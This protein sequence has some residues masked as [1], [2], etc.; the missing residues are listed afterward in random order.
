MGVNTMKRQYTERKYKIEYL[1]LKDKLEW[2][3]SRYNRNGSEYIQKYEKVETI[4]KSTIT[5]IEENYQ[6]YE[7]RLAQII[8]LIHEI[9]RD[10][11]SENEFNMLFDDVFY[12][13]SYQV[14]KRVKKQERWS[15]Y[16]LIKNGII[17]IA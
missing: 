13:L 10:I 1:K 4:I 12:P 16:Q 2:V 7:L 11:R 6:H 5:F 15:Y 17:N 8:A 9:H 14:I 3:F